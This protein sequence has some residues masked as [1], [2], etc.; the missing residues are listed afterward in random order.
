[1]PATE[2]RFD[3]APH[4]IPEQRVYLRELWTD[5]WER[6]NYLWC[7]G[8][9]FSANPAIPKAQF[10]WRYGRIMQPG[11]H[12]FETF[13]R[14]DV[15]RSYVKVEIDDPDDPENPIRWYGILEEDNGEEKGI[16]AGPEEHGQGRQV[17]VA[18][19]LDIMLLRHTIR[20]SVAIGTGGTFA[21]TET[22]LERALEFNAR[23]TQTKEDKEEAG[24]RSAD[25][26]TKST[27][28][29]AG[30]MLGAKFWTTVDIVEYLLA[31]HAPP[32]STGDIQIKWQLDLGDFAGN[33][34]NFDK[35]RKACQ[36]RTLKQLLDELIDRR[37]L[38]GYTVNVIPGAGAN[39]PDRIELSPFTFTAADVN[40]G[41]DQIDANGNLKSLVFDEDP[42][43]SEAVVKRATLDQV[44][45]VVV[46]GERPITCFT[47]SG[48]NGTLV[49]H[50][51]TG[52]EL[53]Y[54]DAAST[55]ADYA[56]LDPSDK[57]DRNK[58]ARRSEQLERVYS[59]FGLSPTWDGRVGNGENSTDFVPYFPEVQ[60]DTLPLPFYLPQL[61]F[62]PL[63][64][65]KTGH[66]YSGSKI[67]DAIVD[68]TP[69]GVA[70]EYSQPRA[71]IRLPDAGGGATRRYARLDQLA[72]STE[73]ELA[74]DGHK[75]SGSLR[76]QH[77]APGIV[78]KVSGQPQHTIA[79]ADF[80][81]LTEDEDP[82]TF[83]WRDNLIVTVAMHVDQYA[84]S[85]WPQVANQTQVVRRVVIDLG[86][87]YKLHYV[88]PQTVLG[89]NPID[90]TLVRSDGGYIRD[91]RPKLQRLARFVYEWY[92]AERQS[93]GLKFEYMTAK[94]KVGD[95]ITTIGAGDTL[96]T[97]NSVV[98]NV[99][100]EFPESQGSRPSTASTTIVTDFAE[101]DGRAFVGQ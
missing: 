49:Q 11:T 34:P 78:V 9:A 3:N 66:D 54:D 47:L 64:P 80:V 10:T 84:E 23:V 4:T 73:S 26:G 6:A 99:S 15:L 17:L 86:E 43:L 96:Q 68:N 90:G 32:D 87:E 101:L 57:V 98:T 25:V 67:P 35:P 81:P 83:N 29:F 100:Y 75:W 89:I 36:H 21:D 51:M 74:P 14:M 42:G 94:L 24:N 20:T 76:M 38:L 46:R 8:V 55:A 95:M 31:Y 91:D 93:L 56:A 82:G 72:T 61:R 65:L 12:T 30:E 70:W 27:Y 92:S 1:M 79:T 62:L 53:A 48:K 19:G 2:I 71:L 41:D 5:P 77:D 16:L 44:D 50:W 85:A 60:D 22:V 58:L 40:F 13:E 7:D 33:L 18:Y 63:L 45:E 88:A 28:V 52:Q 97:I 69:A 37:R 59:Y 39:D